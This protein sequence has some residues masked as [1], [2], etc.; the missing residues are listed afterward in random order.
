MN[1]H[2]QRQVWNLE[3]QRKK[4]I[5]IFSSFTVSHKKHCFNLPS[6]VLLPE[7]THVSL[8]HIVHI[9][10][11]YLSSC[12]SRLECEYQPYVDYA[13]MIGKLLTPRKGHS[14]N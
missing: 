4:V 10:H 12:N 5:F 14:H 6:T 7:E 2:I 13:I 8:I 11:I 1:L 3:Y 9:T